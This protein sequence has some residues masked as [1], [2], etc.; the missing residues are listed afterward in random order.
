MEILGDTLQLVA[1]EKAGIIKAGVPVIT[2]VQP[3]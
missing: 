2:A 1:A 3:H